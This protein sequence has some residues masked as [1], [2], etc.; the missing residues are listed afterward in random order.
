MESLMRPRPYFVP[1]NHAGVDLIRPY[2]Y[3]IVVNSPA[4]EYRYIGKGSSPSR[5]NAYLRNVERVLEG[6][7][8]RPAL[9]RDG[10]PQSEGNQKYRYVHLVLATAVLRGWPIT[11]IAL[12]NCEKAEHS[13]LEK[14]RMAEHRCNMNNGP[15]WLVTDFARLTKQVL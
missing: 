12:E 8:K 2:L 14:R 6:K 5:M 7:T 3:L 4:M 1:S 11:Q 13:L 9:T 15:S 10:R